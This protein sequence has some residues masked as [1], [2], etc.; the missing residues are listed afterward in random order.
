M[1]SR[2]RSP[3]LHASISYCWEFTFSGLLAWR[4]TGPVLRPVATGR[5]RAS[6]GWRGRIKDENPN[7]V[8]GFH[9]TVGAERGNGFA[10]YRSADPEPGDQAGRL[11]VQRDTDPLTDF[12]GALWIGF[13]LHSK[14]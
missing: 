10:D 5:R 3:S 4:I 2:L 13:R 8:P 14:G 1:K 7:A 6:R 12:R 11:T 9:Q